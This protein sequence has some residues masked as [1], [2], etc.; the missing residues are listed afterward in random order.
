MRRIAIFAVLSAVAGLALVGCSTNRQY[1]GP[2]KSAAEQAAQPGI[3]QKNIYEVKVDHPYAKEPCRMGFI[4]FDDVGG[5]WN[6]R[7]LTDVLDDIKKQDKKLVMFVF[8]HGWQNS[9]KVWGDLEKYDPNPEGDVQR[10]KNFLLTMANLPVMKASGRKVYGVFL[11]WR[12]ELV[13]KGSDPVS[14][15]LLRLPRFMTFWSRRSAATRMGDAASVGATLIALREVARPHPRP[16]PEDPILVFMGHSFGSKVLEQAVAQW[17]AREAAAR[18]ARE[19]TDKEIE[20]PRFAD[21]VMFVNSAGESIYSRRIRGL[22]PDREDFCHMPPYF[23]GVTSESDMATKV[24]FPIATTI[25]SILGSFPKMATEGVSSALFFRRT[26][27]FNQFMLN[28]FV[29][30]MPDLAWRL[31]GEVFKPD[32]K[33]PKQ[34]IT[35]KKDPDYFKKTL[36]I[37]QQNMQAKDARGTGAYRIYTTD[38]GVSQI[39]LMDPKENPEVKNRSGFW[40]FKVDKSI[41]NGHSDIWNLNAIILYAK[42]FRLS[43]PRRVDGTKVEFPGYD[44]DVIRA[45]LQPDL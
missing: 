30:T 40:V 37:V 19:G 39:D 31:P 25:G 3:S 22:L 6:A 14:E 1:H 35:D 17:M 36:E 4:E 21:L 2:L 27:P 23:V 20:I 44:P 16:A 11:G 7:Q 29:E 10:F 41:M 38:G 8:I 26:T 45:K 42:L 12:G 34:P 18:I 28:G 5:F 24:A 9:A 13:S 43:C 32:A 15:Q 33:N